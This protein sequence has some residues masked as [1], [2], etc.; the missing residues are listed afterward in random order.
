MKKVINK[1][2]GLVRVPSLKHQTALIPL[3]S[4]LDKFK[5]TENYYVASEEH[6]IVVGNKDPFSDYIML[7]LPLQNRLAA[8]G[9]K[10]YD[11]EGNELSLWQTGKIEFDEMEHER[12]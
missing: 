1:G 6:K 7:P 9:F 2:K 3:Q 11:G 4:L 12:Q 5:K 8:E 10:A